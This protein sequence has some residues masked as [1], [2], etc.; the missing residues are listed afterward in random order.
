MKKRVTEW[1]FG[2]QTFGV[3]LR[4]QSGEDWEVDLVEIHQSRKEL[5][6]IDK[7]E[8][9]R[10][11][12]DLWEK[13]PAHG[14]I[15]LNLSGTGIL[16]KEVNTEQ[17]EDGIEAILPNVKQEEFVVQNLSLKNGRSLLAMMRRDA[18]ASILSEFSKRNI[19]VIDLYLG[20]VSL[21][22]IKSLFAEHTN[23]IQFSGMELQLESGDF[24][25][26]KRSEESDS[27]YYTLAGESLMSKQIL[28][29]AAAVAS[30]VGV[31]SEN[32]SPEIANLSQEYF[33]RQ[34]LRKGAFTGLIILFLAV[35]INFFAFDSLRKKQS[36]L[37]SQVETGRNL[38]VKLDE[39]RSNFSQK[40]EF[41]KK[42]GLNT[43]SRLS[44]YADRLA[45]DLPERVRLT[46]MEMN[47]LMKKIREGKEIYLG[48]GT[49]LVKGETQYPLELNRWIQTLKSEEWV[50]ELKKQ[51]YFLKQ[52]NK[53]A[54]F[55]IEISVQ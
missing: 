33:A 39:L 31:H 2:K 48:N 47:P 15:S 17:L 19:W 16:I 11:T 35:L 29:F 21:Q 44:F 10:C 8:S 40:E 5:K 34:V 12:E 53:P 49:I 6:L 24:T 9:V 1:L 27:T 51:E 28:P 46:T 3:S 18:L 23:R 52:K 54:E 26:F 32:H 30:V 4:L 41:L 7:G 36:R 37:S 55:V 43:N 20:P 13:L 38:L 25:S 42:S 22:P 14:K 45:A 50:A